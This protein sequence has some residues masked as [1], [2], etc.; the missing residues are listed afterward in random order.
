M[1]RASRL[2]PANPAILLQ[3]GRSHGLG[4]DYA[5]AEQ[6]F[7]RAVR[8]A[9]RKTETLAAAGIYSRDFRSPELAER[10]FRRAVEQKDVSAETLIYLAELY[11]RLRRN[12]EAAQLIDR[13]LQMNGACPMA[14]LARARLERQT[15]QW[16]EAEKRLRSIPRTADRDTRVRSLY[17]LGAILDRAGTIR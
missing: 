14:L 3:L 2:D 17:E 6:S 11:E 7:E 9:P 16:A 15:G 13:A 10:Y 4:F 12:A 8:V 5:A 1:E